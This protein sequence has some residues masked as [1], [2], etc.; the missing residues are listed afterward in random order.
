MKHKIWS[1]ASHSLLISM[2]PNC[3]QQIC[4]H[5][6]IWL[7]MLIDN[8]K[9]DYRS[10]FSFSFSCLHYR[11]GVLTAASTRSLGWQECV[12][13]KC[14]RGR[15]ATHRQILKHL[16]TRWHSFIT[17]E[18][19]RCAEA[20]CSVS[21]SCLFVGLP[22]HHPPRRLHH[23]AQQPSMFEQPTVTVTSGR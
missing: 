10:R 13:I 15:L 12:V 18:S 6:P 5:F 2:L 9:I 19:N 4:D 14:E 7:G 22:L 8:R 1:N 11:F 20:V 21:V 23:T 16:L 17:R 3:S